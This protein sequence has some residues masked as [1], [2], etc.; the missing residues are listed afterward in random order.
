MA[1]VGLFIINIPLKNMV[2]YMDAQTQKSEDGLMMV[3]NNSF[4]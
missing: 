4:L 2:E 3:K 1:F